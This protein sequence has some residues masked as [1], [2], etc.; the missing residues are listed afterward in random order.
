MDSMP[1]AVFFGKLYAQRVFCSLSRKVVPG[2][3]VNRIVPSKMQPGIIVAIIR[4]SPPI[5]RQS[6]RVRRFVETSIADQLRCQSALHPFEHEFIEL[7][8]KQRAYLTLDLIR[9]DINVGRKRISTLL[10]AKNRMVKQIDSA[11]KQS[12]R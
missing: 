9:T 8:I 1:L 3:I 11:E 6:N 4:L 2:W 5:P 10:R 7:A 12:E